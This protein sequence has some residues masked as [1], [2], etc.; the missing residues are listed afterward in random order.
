MGRNYIEMG[1]TRLTRMTKVTKMTKHLE[2]RFQQK[3]R[4]TVSRRQG[5]NLNLDL[6]GTE[7]DRN[8]Y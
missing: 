3:K 4:L 8:E 7:I 5:M 2:I 1:Q 6:V